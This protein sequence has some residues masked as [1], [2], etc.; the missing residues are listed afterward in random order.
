MEQL[1]SRLY[2]DPKTGYINAQALHEKARELDPKITLKNVKDWYATQSEIQRF[3]EQSSD[4]MG[5]KSPRI[6]QTR[7]KLTLLSGTAATVLVAL[8]AF[9]RSNKVDIITSDNGSEF[10][11]SKAQQL[12]KAKKIEHYNNE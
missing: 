7:G 5:S 2:Y 11:N 10:M 4:S 8:N 1:L 6:S 12:F 9:I 3:Q